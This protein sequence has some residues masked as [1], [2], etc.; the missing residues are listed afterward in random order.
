MTALR[1][2]FVPDLAALYGVL[3]RLEEGERAS[4]DLD[5]DTF[6]ALGW[7]VQRDRWMALSPLSRTPL[8]LPKASRRTD[9]AALVVPARWDWSAGM[10]AGRATAWCRS[11]HPEGHPESLWFE[12]NSPAV[13]ALALL[14]A[15]LHAQRAILMRATEEACRLPADRWACDC[16]WIG[17]RDAGRGG[18]CPDCQRQ[19]HEAA[20]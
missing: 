2:R 3:L 17:P 1:L 15:G 11:P 14:R 16:G 18:A 4:R 9:C 19:I 10:R 12:A 6:E 5:A 13:P 8:P 20:A 7:R